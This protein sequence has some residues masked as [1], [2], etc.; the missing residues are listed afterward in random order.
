LW[1]LVIDYAV[2]M[3]IHSEQYIK[4]KLYCLPLLVILLLNFKNKFCA[5]WVR[6]RVRVPTF[7]SSIWW[8]HKTGGD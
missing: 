4:I 8:L 5:P 2:E 6:V 1:A 3:K 7:L